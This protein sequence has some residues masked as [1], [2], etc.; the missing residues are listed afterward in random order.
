MKKTEQTSLEGFKEIKGG[1]IV[2][3]EKEGDFT[4]GELVDVRTDVGRHNSTMYDLQNGDKLL[5]VWGSTVLDG[6]MKRVSKRTPDRAGE[7]VKIVFHGEK[8]NKEGTKYK[9]FAVGVKEP[10]QED[11]L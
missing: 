8:T 10:S 9:D 6:K 7:W 5:S 11:D 1:E 4:E 3:F 2:S